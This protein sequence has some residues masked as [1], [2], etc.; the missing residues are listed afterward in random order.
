MNTSKLRPTLLTLATA[1]LVTAATQPV[2]A[3]E[4]LCTINEVS[5][6]ELSLDNRSPELA[7]YCV[8]GN[9]YAWRYVRGSESTCAARPAESLRLWQSLAQ[10]SL[11]SGKTLRIYYDNCAGFNQIASIHLIK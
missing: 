7:L 1:L 4:S 6:A 9:F 5:Y 10:A 11:L 2:L 8:E 3:A